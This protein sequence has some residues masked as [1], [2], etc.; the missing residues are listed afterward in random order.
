LT[1]NFS[2]SVEADIVALEASGNQFEA[3]MD[4]L[5]ASRLASEA[6]IVALSDNSEPRW[7]AEALRADVRAKLPSDM[8]PDQV[9]AALEAAPKPSLWAFVGA[10]SCSAMLRTLRKRSLVSI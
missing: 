6:T 10:L 3:V 9:V 4:S 8:P 5:G 1:E 2:L 7:F